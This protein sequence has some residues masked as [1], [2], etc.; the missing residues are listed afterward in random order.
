[1]SESSVS[2]TGA[3]VPSSSGQNSS[4]AHP[5]YEEYDAG[6]KLC[7]ASLKRLGLEPAVPLVF[8]KELISRGT[9]L[10]GDQQV[11]LSSNAF[12][13]KTEG[14]PVYQYHVDFTK[15]LAREYNGGNTFPLVHD[16]NDPRYPNRAPRKVPD[17]TLYQ[18]RFLHQ[19]LL[20]AFIC[21]YPSVFGK[22][23][24]VFCYDYAATLFSLVEL[25]SFDTSMVL[26][27]AE[28]KK[29]ID[30]PYKVNL[31]L[32]KPAD[33][34]FNIRDWKKNVGD[35]ISEQPAEIIRFFELA[36]SRYASQH[37]EDHVM[38]E[39]KKT[40]YMYPAKFGMDSPDLGGGK[41][42]ASGASKTVVTVEGPRNEG[43]PAVIIDSKKTPFYHSMN[44]LEMIC[45]ALQVGPDITPNRRHWEFAVKYLKRLEC[46]PIY[47]NR[48][49]S[50]VLLNSLTN[51]SA[52]ETQMEYK[53]NQISIVQYLQQRYNVE[54]RFPQ[55]PLATGAK[56]IRGSHV[57]IP[58]ELLHVADY[59]RV[60]NVNISSSDI[61]TIVKA[62]AV[63]P[64]VKSAEIMNC[65]KSFAFSADGFMNGAHMA[66]MD[67]PLNVHARVIQAPAIAYANGN[68]NPEQNGKWRL[69]RTAKYVRC[70]SLKS[71]C[72]LFLTAP[73]ERMVLGEFE[74]FVVKYFQE[75][76]NRGI[77]LGEPTKIWSVGCEYPQIENAFVGANNAECE[78]IL[79][80]HSDRDSAMHPWIKGVERKYGVISQCVRTKTIYNVMKKSP[81]SLENIVA[82]TN[83]KLGGV[84]YNIV[85]ENYPLDP[86]ALFIGLGMNHPAGGMASIDATDA[87]ANVSILGFSA[88][89]GVH[90]GEFIGNFF[91]QPMSR[92]ENVSVIDSLLVEILDRFKANR[93]CT[94]SRVI[95]YRSSCSEGAYG[96]VLRYE[97]PIINAVMNK[98]APG[99]PVT[100]IIPSKMHS[101][102]FFK[103]NINPANRSDDQNIRPGTVVDGVLVNHAYSEFFLNSHLAIQGT[104]KSPKYTIIFSSEKEASLDMFERWTN[105]LCYDFQIVTSPTSLPAPVYIANR[106]AER[107][108]QIYNSFPSSGR[109]NEGVGGNIHDGNGHGGN[110]HGGNGHGGNDHDDDG[111][112]PLYYKSIRYNF[113]NIDSLRDKRINA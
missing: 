64:A 111:A 20:T 35:G 68:L 57:F 61:A 22:D 37:L 24:D 75:C 2:S 60:G 7:L 65:H 71:W 13:L 72:A 11:Q 84:N 1:M 92:D 17:Y 3:T 21:K 112:P 62:C 30:R 99:I 27:E 45:K 44:L 77:S 88:N 66:V 103:Q 109:E 70:S 97:I 6:A 29:T 33:N 47:G 34:V 76:R 8:N 69:P 54:V 110:G 16:E 10:N 49:D 67:I 86:N 53:G 83:V 18:N 113:T 56:K 74:Q 32:K 80:G 90:P 38:Y 58:L 108:R 40:Y 73:G 89:D 55:W 52:H 43:A 105:A 106:Y 95:F 101:L 14:L 107:G 78:F 79:I 96:T 59:Q 93:K 63:Y 85:L 82:K 5:R 102:R 51:T 100:V 87:E 28:T 46:F 12:G 4:S 23:S 39:S 104:A 25:T 98:Y 50:T 31:I 15:T 91:F 41:Y 94:P 26:D 81:L 48:Q 42:L 36:T 19:K 9:L